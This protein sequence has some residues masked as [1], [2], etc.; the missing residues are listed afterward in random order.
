MTANTNFER[1]IADHYA[2]EPHLRAPDRVLHAA[3]ATIDTTRQR[4]DLLAPWRYP[5]M[6]RYMKFAVAAALVIAVGG[7]AIW[8]LAPGGP[9]ATPS[10]SHVPTLAPPTSAPTTYVA[11]PL[12]GTFTSTQYGYS[13]S[14]PEGWGTRAATELWR[15]GGLPAFGNPATD[16][17]YDPKLLDHLFVGAASQPLNG[18]TLDEWQGEFF[19]SEEC[20]AYDEIFIDGAEGWIGFDCEIAMVQA[21]GRGYIFGLWSSND[22]RELR[23]LD[24]RR[25]FQDVL[26][27]VQLDPGAAID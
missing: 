17:I 27:T 15:E 2:G 8:Q 10:P 18:A 25:L 13:L 6:Q 11:P 1:R 9:A 23:A 19:G 7:F 3:L 16:A 24:T 20:G 12:T 21:G 26:A 22:D 4:R 14:Y 5:S